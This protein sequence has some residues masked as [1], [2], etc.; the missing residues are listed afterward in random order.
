LRGIGKLSKPTSAM[1]IFGIY[2]SK[3]AAVA[4]AR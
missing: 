4:V 1:I 3:L 2:G